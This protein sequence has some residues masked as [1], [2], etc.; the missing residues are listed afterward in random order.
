M[1]FDN[2]LFVP[3]FQVYLFFLFIYIINSHRHDIAEI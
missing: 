2:L 3:D 1:F